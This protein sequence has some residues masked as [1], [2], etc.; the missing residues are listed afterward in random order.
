MREYIKPTFS[1]V[2]NSP[3]I[4]LPSDKV[5][6]GSVDV[7]YVYGKPVNGSVTFKFGI[8]NSETGGISFIGLTTSKKLNNGHSDY[9]FSVEEI[10]S[11]FWFPKLNGDI[12][13][14]EAIVQEESTGKKE[15]AIDFST[16]FSSTAYK[17]S[18]QKSFIDF[19]P[20]RK[21]FVIVSI[22]LLC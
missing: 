2:I 8:K 3:K 22:I 20:L 6:K 4:V 13:M 5:I 15:K 19:K 16:K 11:Y 9:K 17:I 1:I 12:L 10:K 21:T 14:V 7:K 18:F